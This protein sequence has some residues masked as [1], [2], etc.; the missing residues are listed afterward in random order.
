[1]FPSMM[2]RSPAC[3]LGMAKPPKQ[4]TWALH[5]RRMRAAFH[6]RMPAT[7]VGALHISP[8]PRLPIS[9]GCRRLSHYLFAHILA[10]FWP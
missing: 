8:P 9:F 2:A 7:A 4:G 5:P 3:A 1:M 10:R 6:R